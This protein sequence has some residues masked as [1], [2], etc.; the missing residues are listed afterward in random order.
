MSAS[1]RAIAIVALLWNLIGVAMFYLQVTMSAE[2][3]AALPAEQRVVYETA[4][5]WI[6]IAFAVAVFGGVFAALALLLRSRLAVP[7]FAVSLLALL[8]QLGAVYALT[9]AFA[10]S[11]VGGLALPAALVL[12]GA[13]QLW[14]ARRARA[15]GWLG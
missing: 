3:L 5:A 14:Y 10:A 11:G 12:L 15:R 9:P 2:T 4:P 6:D 13:V 7:L 1:F 8:V